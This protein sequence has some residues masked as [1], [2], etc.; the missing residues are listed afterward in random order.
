[1]IKKILFIFAFSAFLFSTA[2]MSVRKPDGTEYVNNQTFTFNTYNTSSATLHF[3]VYN[4]SS[5]AS[6]TV[7]AIC[8]SLINTDG[9]AFQFCFSGNCQFNVVQGQ[10]HPQSGTGLVIPAGTN[11]GTNDYFE[12]MS[13]TTSSGVYPAKTKFKIIQV[14]DFGGVVGTPFYITYQYNGVLGVND[15]VVQ[16]AQLLVKNT[17]VKDNVNVS[18]KISAEMNVIDMT[19]KTVQTSNI[20]KGEN[21]INMLKLL[22]GTYILSFNDKERN[23]VTQKIIKN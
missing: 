15:T 22:S 9:S 1:M 19:G 5:T 3:S 17:F 6:I 20:V 16:N 4:T 7:K 21:T 10:E 13:A 2:Q 8:E 23:I 14:D 12:N 18:S 11:T